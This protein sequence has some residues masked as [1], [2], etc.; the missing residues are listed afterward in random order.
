MA[1]PYGAFRPEN[2]LYGDWRP[3]KK[4]VKPK[5]KPKPGRRPP[6]MTIDQWAEQQA[7]KYVDAQV[8]SIEAQR[9]AYL[10]ELQRNA[11]MRIDAGARLAEAM[12]SMGFDTRIQGVYQNA[13]NDVAGMAQ[14]FAGDTRNIAAADAA[15]QA[16]MLS[17]TGQ[18]GAV[19][20]EG[21]AIVEESG[22]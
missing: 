8:A 10:D 5:P 12:R 6:G 1:V 11:Q 9:Q 15:Q 14:G 17:G 13:A 16:R 22:G 3:G 20:N 7:T 18:E 2:S 4:R 19:R 21:V